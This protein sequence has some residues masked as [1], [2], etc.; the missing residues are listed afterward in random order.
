METQRTVDQFMKGLIGN[1]EFYDKLIE[2]YE[3]R[4]ADRTVVMGDAYYRC[5]TG[6]AGQVYF[7]KDQ[8]PYGGGIYYATRDE[9]GDV[10]WIE[11]TEGEEF[12]DDWPPALLPACIRPPH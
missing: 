9:D 3:K 6:P 7:I 4:L 11:C 12:K 2:R 1:L 5:T 8:I 10:K